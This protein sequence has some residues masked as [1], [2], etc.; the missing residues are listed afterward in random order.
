MIHITRPELDQLAEDYFYNFFIK[1]GFLKK[2]LISYLK[3]KNDHRAFLRI[4]LKRIKEII[5]GRPDVLEDI[6]KNEFEKNFPNLLKQIKNTKPTQEAKKKVN[7]RIR[8]YNKFIV[9]TPAQIFSARVE[10]SFHYNSFVN[11][12]DPKSWGA[13]Y[14]AEKLGVNVCPYCNRNFTHTHRPHSTIKGAT[15]PEFDHFYSQDEFPF[16]ALSFFNLVPSCHVCNS[17]FKGSQKFDL[18]LNP[19]D[20][21][22]DDD[23]MFTLK[24]RKRKDKKYLENWYNNPEYFNID[25]KVN[26]LA[27]PDFIE[28]AKNNIKSFQLREL[29][30]NHKDFAME[31]IIKAKIY[32]EDKIN[33]MVTEFPNLF[34]NRES[35]IRLITGNYSMYNEL[36]KRTLSKLIHD[37]A[38][39]YGLK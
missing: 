36:G 9:P 6:L 34:P 12:E 25:F 5:T 16:F 24:I 33:S 31:V 18:H 23:I 21:G 22:F 2:L 37:I 13:K 39:E 4:L 32:D 10:Y 15:R 8:K 17:N 27:D 26:S 14:L 11:V 28:R 30:K 19:Y 38:Q 20:R 3:E 7:S 35:V 1:R 29:Y